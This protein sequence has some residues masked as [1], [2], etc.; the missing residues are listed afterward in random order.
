MR[1]LQSYICLKQA[2]RLDDYDRTLVRSD[3]PVIFSRRLMRSTVIECSNWDASKRRAIGIDELL[4]LRDPSLRQRCQKQF[5]FNI[6]T[7]SG[8]RFGNARWRCINIV[9]ITNYGVLASLA[10]AIADAVRHGRGSQAHGNQPTRCFD[11]LRK[12]FP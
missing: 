9:Y 5:A 7:G 10:R 2:R 3:A 4:R 8:E 12:R 1:N 6:L 11:C